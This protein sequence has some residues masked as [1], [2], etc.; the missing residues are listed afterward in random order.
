MTPINER[1]SPNKPVFRAPWMSMFAAIAVVYGG[2]AL[3]IYTAYRA[4]RYVMAV[5][6]ALVDWALRHGL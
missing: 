1:F 5:N 4:I 3:A 6:A 2:I